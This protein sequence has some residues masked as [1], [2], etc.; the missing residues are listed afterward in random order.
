MALTLVQLRALVAAADQGSFT[1]AASELGVS[2]SAIS[3]AVHGLEREVGG[4]VLHREGQVALTTLGFRVLTHAR[5]VLDAVYAL[6]DAITQDGEPAGAIR[7]GAVA[8]V[9]QGLLPELLP[10][11]NA[12]LPNVEISI[13]E[14]D[15]DEMPEWLESGVVDAA[16]LVEPTPDP[17]G[18]VLLASDEFAA[19]VRADHPLAGLDGIPLAELDADGLIV[20]TGGCEAHVRKMHDEAGLPYVF[21]H[22]VR[23]MST[24]LRM[25]EQ[26]LGVAIVPSLGRD[27]LPKSLIMKPLAQRRPRRLVL[28]GPASRP[29]HPLVQ[30]L[31]DHVA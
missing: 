30:T 5:A 21:T 26:G 4:R 19:V 12:Q 3:H 13:Y 23:E 15:D 16:I 7:L 29:W 17:P 11:W 18:S 22:R 27:M 31:I 2:Q 10:A 28:S 25:V 9:C 14:G 1:D 24:L 6:E 8:T 20:S